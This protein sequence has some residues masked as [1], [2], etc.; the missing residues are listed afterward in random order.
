MQY[1]VCPKIAFTRS[2]W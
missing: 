1:L 2:R